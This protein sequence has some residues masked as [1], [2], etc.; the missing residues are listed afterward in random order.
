[1]EWA[2]VQNNLGNLLIIKNN[3]VNFERA[4]K[5]YREALKIRTKDRF[6]LDYAST[7]D[8]LG[9]ALRKLGTKQKNN[10]YLMEAVEAHK[11]ALTVWTKENNPWDWAMAKTN[12]G[13]TLTRLGEQEG[14]I[15]YL[16]EAKESFLD[17]LTIRS[18]EKFPS[19]W[20]DTLNDYGVVL[21]LVNE[22]I[23]L[24]QLEVNKTNRIYLKQAIMAFSA[25]LAQDNSNIIFR[26]NLDHAI[27][28]DENT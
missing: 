20:A 8:N 13:E 9:N 6:P 26:Q 10:T 2:S 4:I 14:R 24:P 16:K 19:A 23:I 5:T 1:M 21:M 27:K 28:Q 25:A 7:Q 15:D 12:L 11:K 3:D 17:A 22:R 18:Q